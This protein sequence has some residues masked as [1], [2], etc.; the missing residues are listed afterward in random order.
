MTKMS[1]ALDCRLGLKSPFAILLCDF[2]P[3]ERRLGQKDLA[4]C[5]ARLKV[6]GRE[7]KRSWELTV[8]HE[9]LHGA[10]HSQWVVAHG[11]EGGLL[12]S[13]GK[14][15]FLVSLRAGNFL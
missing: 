13:K 11:E 2:A 14:L 8:W 1:S 12:N 9:V 4:P 6:H 7:P 10:T 3:S 15:Y 5:R